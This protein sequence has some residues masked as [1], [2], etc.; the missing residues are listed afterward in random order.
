[1]DLVSLSF[2]GIAGALA[3]RAISRTRE[4]RSSAAGVADLL[5]WAFMVDE[6]VILQKDGSLLAGW[7]YQ[8]PD[9]S[10]ATAQELD[11]LFRHVN[12]AL[13]P[14]TDEW[15]LHLDAIRRPAMAYSASAFPDAITQLIDDER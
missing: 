15:M 1:M 5:N 9:V 10:A 7:R 12:E 2:G 11:N 14:L 3:S 8:G 4:H 13:L 6:G